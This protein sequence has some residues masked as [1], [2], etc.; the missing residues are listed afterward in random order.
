MIFREEIVQVC[1]LRAWCGIH[2][3]SLTCH[4]NGIVMHLDDLFDPTIKACGIC[5]VFSKRP[6]K[7]R[8]AHGCEIN[9]VQ[10]TATSMQYEILRRMH[11]TLKVSTYLHY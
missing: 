3:Q 10:S 1:V 9:N 7:Y 6:R 8:Y 11:F 2:K 4:I 5:I